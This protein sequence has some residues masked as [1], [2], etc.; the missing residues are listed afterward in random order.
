MYSKLITSIIGICAFFGM[1]IFAGT[2]LKDKDIGIAKSNEAKSQPETQA[3]IATE[4]ELTKSSTTS[5]SDNETGEEISS[6][7]SGNANQNADTDNE[8]V[9]FYDVGHTDGTPQAGNLETANSATAT[10]HTESESAVAQSSETVTLEPVTHAHDAHTQVTT[11]PNAI[12][13]PTP[14]TATETTTTTATNTPVAPSSHQSKSGSPQID[15]AYINVLLQAETNAP[16]DGAKRVLQTARKMALTDKVMIQG[17]CWDYINAVY[18][19]AGVPQ[20]KRRQLFNGEYKTGPYADQ[21][22]FQPADW[23]YFVNHGYN[24]VE[25]SSLFI[26]WTDRANNKALMLTYG[27]ENRAEPARYR[28]YDLSHVYGIVRPSSQAVTSLKR[29]NAL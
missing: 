4:D 17:S 10:N 23:L 8:H 27:G 11:Q 7:I 21:N 14:Q 16:N 13:E 9:V 12:T 15:P 1:L 20:V 2:A 28:V 22:L 19:D 6:N 18:N 26:G 3:G 24:N 25:H 29:P 5:L